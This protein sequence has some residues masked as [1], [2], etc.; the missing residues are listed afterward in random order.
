[1][2]PLGSGGAGRAVQVPFFSGQAA[3]RG[4][5]S[6]KVLPAPMP[7]KLYKVGPSGPRATATALLLTG[8]GRVISAPTAAVPRARGRAAARGQD[9]IE[10]LPQVFTVGA[11]VCH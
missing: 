4:T 10:K 2:R 9:F 7:R 8:Q 1:M 5:M 3:A 11:G 6:R